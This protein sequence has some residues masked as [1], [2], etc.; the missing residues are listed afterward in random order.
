MNLIELMIGLLIF[1]VFFWVV[2]MIPGIPAFVK[3]VV[4]VILAV[5]LIIWVLQG[6]GLVGSLNTPMLK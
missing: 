1:G 3:Q 2:S 5:I 6:F 4:T